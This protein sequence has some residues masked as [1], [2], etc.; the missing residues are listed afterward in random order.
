[1]HGVCMDVCMGCMHGC[2]HG[3]NVCVYGKCMYVCT[4]YRLCNVCM[5]VRLCV[6]NVSKMGVV[7]KEA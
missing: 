1:M 3:C 7:H 5:H 4:V 6:I 2:M